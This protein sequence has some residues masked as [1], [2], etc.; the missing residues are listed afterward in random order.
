MIFSYDNDFLFSFIANDQYEENSEEYIRKE[1]L[2]ALGD[3]IDLMVERTG[4]IP[5]ERSGK[6]LSCVSKVGEK[7]Y[8][9]GFSI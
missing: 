1:L 5:T 8:E 7:N 3:D 6:F 9:N 2:Q 4:Y